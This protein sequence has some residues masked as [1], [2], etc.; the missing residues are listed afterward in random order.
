MRG[1]RRIRLLASMAA[2]S[3][4]ALFVLGCGDPY[5]SPTLAATAPP[6]IRVRLGSPVRTAELLISDQGWRAQALSGA[7]FSASGT[8]GLRTRLAIGTH[9]GGAASIIFE[10]RDT[11]SQLLV[12]KPQHAF[13][14]GKVAYTGVLRIAIRKGRLELVNELDLETY[15]AGVIGNEVGPT[16]APATY[17]AQAVAAR[18]YAWIQIS[19]PDARRRAFHL[20]DSA[21]SQVYRGMSPRYGVA[22]A[23]MLRYTR[24]TAGVIMTWKARP[25]RAYYSS[26]CGGH[27]TDWKSSQLDPGGAGDVLQGVPCRWC[28]KS[29]YYSWPKQVVTDA[30]LLAGMKRIK[31]PVITPLI[32]IDIVERG[33]GEW[34]RAADIVYGAKRKKRRVTGPELR[35]AL[36]V[37]SHNIQTI[38]RITGGFQVSGKGWGHG[39]G[40]CQVGAIYMGQAGAS[41]TEILR[42]YYPGI[43]FRKVY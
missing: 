2:S 37:R 19:A 23:D 28:K 35:T 42:Y 21:S 7:P 40:M 27:T 8:R 30:A 12:V 14:L 43:A 22:Y 31:K 34:V 26:T 1:S 20:Y 15:V 39:V 5:A 11:G 6:E 24:A 18:T 3:L 10:G 25:F 33:R 38:R 9:G 13:T 41:E 36:G 29:K 32:A 4:L 16:G 17:R